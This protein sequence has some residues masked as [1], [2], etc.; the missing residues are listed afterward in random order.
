MK[1][2]YFILSIANITVNKNG[3]KIITA[4]DLKNSFISSY[5]IISS[6]ELLL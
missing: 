2:I 1:K 3:K 6:S 4:H 5:P